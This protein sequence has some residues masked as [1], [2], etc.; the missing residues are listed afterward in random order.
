MLANDNVES[1]LGEVRGERESI[2]GGSSYRH[3][4]LLSETPTVSGY[5]AT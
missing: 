2:R 5:W 4:L 1:I 3:P